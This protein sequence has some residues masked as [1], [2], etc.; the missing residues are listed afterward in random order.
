MIA[1]INQVQTD[2]V[3]SK[4]QGQI[5]H[6]LIRY[7]CGFFSGKY[8]HQVCAEVVTLSGPSMQKSPQDVKSFCDYAKTMLLAA[9]PKELK[10]GVEK[11]PV[12]IFTDGCWEKGFAGIGA[13]ILDTSKGSR[14]VCSGVVPQALLEKWKQMVGEYVICQ[15]ELYVLVLVRWQFCEL[16]G[17]SIMIRLASVQSRASAR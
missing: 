7:A 3:L 1:L 9:K 8:L 16:C 4:H 15:I 17:G 6:G 12:L 2:G 13:V 5:I 14:M 10:S 11:R